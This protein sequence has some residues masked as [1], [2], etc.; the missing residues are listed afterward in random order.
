MKKTRIF[1]IS[2]MIFPALGFMSCSDGLPDYD[3]VELDDWNNGTRVKV[4]VDSVLTESDALN[5]S[6]KVKEKKVLGDQNAEIWFYT[7]RH[8]DGVPAQRVSFAAGNPI[9]GYTI[10]SASNKEIMRARD[11]TL[12]GFPGKEIIAEM[13]IPD[14]AMKNIIFK[15]NNDYLMSTLT[16]DGNPNPPDTLIL[17]DE[18][19]KLIS[20]FRVKSGVDEGMIIRIDKSK[21]LI[22]FKM[23][24]SAGIHI[25]DLL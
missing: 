18:D 7:S 1:L 21:K 2:M 10:N 8:A 22:T 23:E 6:E 13:L 16:L 4:V 11:L 5:I 24:D 15:V 17:Y 3:I 9:P 19:S 12:D 20:S 25:Y 14:I